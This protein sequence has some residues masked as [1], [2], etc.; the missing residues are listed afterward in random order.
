MY[1]IVHNKK[2]M[3][4]SHNIYVAG[5]NFCKPG[6]IMVLIDGDDMA[7][8]RQVFSLLNAYYQQNKPAIVYTQFL[9]IRADHVGNATNR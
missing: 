9:F 3:G 5:N 2:N 7:I 1:T 8:G 6:Q 4:G